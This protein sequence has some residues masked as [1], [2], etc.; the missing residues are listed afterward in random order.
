MDC[1]QP[2]IASV[3]AAIVCPC[4]KSATPC[5]VDPRSRFFY[6]ESLASSVDSVPAIFVRAFPVLSAVAG[7]HFVA[8]YYIPVA[9]AAAVGDP[10]VVAHVISAISFP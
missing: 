3:P 2:R 10:A 1:Y 9:S 7:I 8:N 6:Y 4:I 5:I